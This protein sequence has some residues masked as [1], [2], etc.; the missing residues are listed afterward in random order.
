MTTDEMIE[1]WLSQTKGHGKAGKLLFN[2]R[3][4]YSYG[5]HFTCGELVKNERGEWSCFLNSQRYSNTTSMHQC[6]VGCAVINKGFKLFHS[7]DCTNPGDGKINSGYAYNQALRYIEERLSMAL[8]YVGK[9]SRA[10]SRSYIPEIMKEIQEIKSFLDFYNLDKRLT[11]E[12]YDLAGKTTYHSYPAIFD[13]IVNIDTQELRDIWGCSMAET[14][15]RTELAK[16]LNK[17]GVW[18]IQLDVQNFTPI[19]WK[20]CDRIKHLLRKTA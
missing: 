3:L 7:N 2:N 19:V 17:C 11:I 10:R 16:G 1:A 12:T 18:G 15:E 20:L 6:W 5:K 14:L 4:I 8:Y 13:Y 9:Q